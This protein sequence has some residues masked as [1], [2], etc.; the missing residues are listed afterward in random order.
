LDTAEFERARRSVFGNFASLIIDSVDAIANDVAGCR[1]MGMG[2]F[3]IWRMPPR[4]S[5]RTTSCAALGAL[6]DDMSCPVGEY[7]PSEPLCN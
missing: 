3:A 7:S 1:F 6:T 4:A 2:P 5:P